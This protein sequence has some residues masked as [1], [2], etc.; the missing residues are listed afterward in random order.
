MFTSVRGF[1]SGIGLVG[2]VVE[3]LQSGGWIV[4][5]LASEEYIESSIESRIHEGVRSSKMERPGRSGNGNIRA[6]PKK[7]ASALGQ[8]PRVYIFRGKVEAEEEGAW[9]PRKPQRERCRAQSHAAV[10]LGLSVA[11][12]ER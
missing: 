12:V 7:Q 8:G 1:L 5:Y 4:N 10:P 3:Q 2:G 11:R 9:K 6:E